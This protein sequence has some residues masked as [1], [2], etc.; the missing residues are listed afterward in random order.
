MSRQI[1]TKRQLVIDILQNLEI[2]KG[3]IHPEDVVNLARDES[4]PLHSHFTWDNTR[5]G[6]LYRKMEAR[7]L[8][9]TVKV[10]WMGEKKPTYFN[11]KV[12]DTRGYVSRPTIASNTEMQNQVVTYAAKQ[13]KHWLDTY[14][15]VTELSGIVDENKLTEIITKERSNLGRS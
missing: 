6:E 1:S 15:D 7:V 5:A 10:E 11:V 3:A 8:I 12:K 2:E 9:N 13:L 14:Q 4:S